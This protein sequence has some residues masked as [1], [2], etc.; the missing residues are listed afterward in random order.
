METKDLLALVSSYKDRAESLSTQYLAE[1]E[2]SRQLHREGAY[3]SN[4]QINDGRSKMK[5]KVVRGA[6]NN[7]SIALATAFQRQKSV[8]VI[9]APNKSNRIVQEELII[10]KQFDRYSGGVETI[11]KWANKGIKEGV[12]FV[13]VGMNV[14]YDKEKKTM[15]TVDGKTMFDPLELTRYPVVSIVEPENLYVPYGSDKAQKAPYVVH[16]M[17]MVRSE[18][19]K[20]DKAYSKSGI[21]TDT[22]SIEATSVDNTTSTQEN[23]NESFQ[24]LNFNDKSNELVEF[25]EFWGNLDL[26]GDGI[27]E[28]VVVAFSKMGIHRQQLNPFPKGIIPFLSWTPPFDVKEN[29]PFGLSLAQALKDPQQIETFVKQAII[30]HSADS[31][32]PPMA[33]NKMVVDPSNRNKILSRDSNQLIELNMPLNQSVKDVIYELVPAPLSPQ[34]MSLS[35]MNEQEKKLASG[36]SSYHLSGGDSTNQY[37]KAAAVNAE[38]EASDA[39]LNMALLSFSNFM[40]DI[41]TIYVQFNNEYLTLKDRK[42]LLPD[43]EV[44]IATRLSVLKLNIRANT[45]RYTAVQQQKLMM[46]MQNITAIEG[47][48]PEKVIVDVLAGALESMGAIEIADKLFEWQPHEDPMRAQQ[49]Q[50]QMEGEIAKVMKDKAQA[51]RLHG[52]TMVGM[53]AVQN[54]AMRDAERMKLENNRMILG[55]EQHKDK[56]KHADNLGNIQ[57]LDHLHKGK[58]LDHKMDMESIKA[59]LDT[60]THFVGGVQHA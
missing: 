36:L 39:I 2:E 23:K 33:V 6:V 27:A 28:P 59:A 10:N 45:T 24:H 53:Q 41:G 51:E 3:D 58:E 25:F 15:K 22:D 29:T 21:Y 54:D 46:V 56:M 37:K 5:P 12:L 48:V 50:L 31:V 8:F 1:I 30:N 4:S 35:A 32:N 44:A 38:S 9:E 18:L 34:F 17:V 26:D 16:R 60:L 11:R 19:R 14:D 43:D 47:K 13:R 57:L 42:L 7:M 20:L 49:A 52:Q 55:H 40:S